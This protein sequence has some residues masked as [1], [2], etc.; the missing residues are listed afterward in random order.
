MFPLS[1]VRAIRGIPAAKAAC[2]SIALLA[3][4]PASSVAQTGPEIV[5]TVK[6]GPGPQDVTLTWTGGQPPFEIYRSA[7]VKSVCL[8]ASS[9]G[10]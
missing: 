10:R 6:T 2:L 9:I 8:T 5:L 3:F 1:A 4:L 7:D